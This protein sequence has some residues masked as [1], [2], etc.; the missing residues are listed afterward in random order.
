Q[1]GVV[2]ILIEPLTHN[3]TRTSSELRATFTRRN[4][5]M[6]EPGSVAGIFEKKGEVVVDAQRYSQDDVFPPVGAGAEDINLDENVYEV[7]AAPE[8]F[9]DVKSSLEQAG[10]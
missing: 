7:I 8:S 4:G 3:R 6:G 1:P 9:M 5:N 10:V 2:E